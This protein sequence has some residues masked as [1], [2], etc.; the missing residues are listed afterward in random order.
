MSILFPAQSR[1]VLGK[2]VIAFIFTIMNSSAFA[3]RSI[4]GLGIAGVRVLCI[5]FPHVVISIGAKRLVDCTGL[6]LLMLSLILSFGVSIQSFVYDPQLIICFTL[7][8]PMLASKMAALQEEL[9]FLKIFS[10]T[11]IIFNVME[12]ICHVILFVEMRK[13]HKRHVQLCLQNKPKLAKL[14]K[15]R[16]TISAIGHFTSWFAEMLISGF[17]YYI[18]VGSGKA[19][20]FGQFYLWLFTPS[21]NFVIFPAVQALTS[22][23]LRGHVFRLDLLPELCFNIHCKFKTGS[24]DVEGEDAHDIELQSNNGSAGS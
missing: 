18:I 11:C 22:D 4:G 5:G 3:Y 1:V 10:I 2:S 12:F 16:N 19:A 20:E 23:D 6:G 17:L 8:Y 7:G 9:I 24:N 21:I 13:H 14:K 15:R